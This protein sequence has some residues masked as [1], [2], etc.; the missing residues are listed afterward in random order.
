MGS[1]LTGALT[2]SELVT[3]TEMAPVGVGP[4]SPVTAAE[5]VPDDQSTDCAR[6]GFA[7]VGRD[8]LREAVGRL[9][10]ALG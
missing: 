9:V 10:A 8:Q 6:I 1:L 4:W 7:A 3:G 2:L 5:L